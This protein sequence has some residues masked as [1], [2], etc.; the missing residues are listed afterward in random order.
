V[1]E[2]ALWE[3]CPEVIEI[4]EKAGAKE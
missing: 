3:G 4:L 1:L 2:F